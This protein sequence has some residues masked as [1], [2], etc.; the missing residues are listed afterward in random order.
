MRALLAR[1]KRLEESFER[2]AA[3][4][5]TQA[6][7]RNLSLEE[8]AEAR[9][10]HAAV[11]RLFDSLEA[12]FPPDPRG[13]AGGPRLATWQK[14]AAAGERL[15]AGESVDADRCALSALPADALRILGCGPEEFLAAVAT[16]PPRLE[17]AIGAEAG[18][19]Q[20]SRPAS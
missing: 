14:V 8:Q 2:S 20:R 5:A 4:E 9:A 15:R 16:L 17:P 7:A 3:R 10:R 18:Q 11:A 6:A 12:S 13:V 1:I 19:Y